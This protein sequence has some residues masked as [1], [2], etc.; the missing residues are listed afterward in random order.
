MDLL[1]TYPKLSGNGGIETVLSSLLTNY[2]DKDIGIQL[3]LPGGTEDTLWIRNIPGHSK[4][5]EL[6]NY[7]TKIGQII[8]T[9]K[10]ILKVR[11]KIVIVMSKS[12]IIAAALARVF[13]KNMKILSWNHFSLT[14][15]SSNKNLWLFKLCDAHLSIS[16]GISRQ[17]IELG[18]NE[19]SIHTI[20]NPIVNSHH[21]IHRSKSNVHE[22]YYIGRI[23][24]QEQKNISE[25]FKILSGLTGSW[26][27]NVIGTGK[28]DD[29]DRLKILA[30]HLKIENR[31][32]WLGW[33]EK[34]WDK[35]ESADAVVLT[36]NYEGLPMTLCEAIAHGIPVFSSNCKTGPEDII[37]SGENGELY[38]LHN[39]SD[40][41]KK[42]EMTLNS[43]NYDDVNKISDT[44]N[45]F[46]ESTY[47]NRFQSIVHSFLQ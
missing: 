46:F 9:L 44:A 20:Y 32:N 4:N 31:I 34:P 30:S 28:A 41:V 1:I 39:I 2:F 25:L 40:G 36:S 37:R 10:Y 3:F 14:V 17:L 45:R 26:H 33:I 19:D 11:P 35:I 21:M 13:V 47:Y 42:L 22:I 5:I 43:S 6:H 27:L 8:D 18:I 38:E 7:K 23:Q 15:T 16:S 29:M 24:F 12:Q